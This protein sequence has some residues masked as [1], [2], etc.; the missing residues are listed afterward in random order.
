MQLF[1]KIF[2][3]TKSITFDAGY[4]PSCIF[5]FNLFILKYLK[6]F[7]SKKNFIYR[8]QLLLLF[9]F[10]INFI[11]IFFILANFLYN[12]FSIFFKKKGLD[13]FYFFD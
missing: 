6:A 4:L 11:V 8:E 9:K 5:F 7:F 2:F 10:F 1:I 12:L 3:L 13:F